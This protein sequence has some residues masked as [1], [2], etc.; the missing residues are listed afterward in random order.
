M[1]ITYSETWTTLGN[2]VSDSITSG[3]IDVSDSDGKRVVVAICIVADDLNTDLTI[4]NSGTALSWTQIQQTDTLSNCRLAAW[5]AFGDANGNRTITVS[6]T[7]GSSKAKSLA[8][9]VH[10]GAHQTTPQPVGNRFS[11][12]GATDVSQAITP[13]ATGSALWMAAGDWNQTNSYAGIANCTIDQTHNLA[14]EYTSALIR[15]TTQPRTD[16]AAFTIGETDTSGLIAWLAFEI[17][18]ADTA[19]PLKR[20]LPQFVAKGTFSGLAT[21]PTP[22]MPTFNAGDLLVIAIESA[23]EAIATPTGYTQF[24]N[25]PQFTGTAAAAGGVRLGAFYRVAVAGDTAPTIADS[26]NHTCAQIYSIRGID[27]GSPVNITAG[28]TQAATTSVSFPTVTTTTDNCLILLLLANDRDIAGT[29]NISA[30]ANAALAS[31]T[32]Q[33]DEC[34]TA[35]VGGGLCTTTGIKLL[36]GAVGATTATNAASVT[37][38]TLTIALQGSPKIPDWTITQKFTPLRM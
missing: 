29:T 20:N 12:V 13:T 38:A 26:G 11:G 36:E 6:H 27:S 5:W 31:I 10:T 21:A 35:G 28:T 37:N 18:A 7:G 8:T 17:Q 30:Q 25:S 9:I 2:G 15:P 4:A 24:A 32:E 19:V 16:A 34:I 1:A 22:G 3:S 14:G 23:N 33:H